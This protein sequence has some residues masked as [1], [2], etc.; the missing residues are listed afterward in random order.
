MSGATS[1]PGVTRVT[2]E[3]TTSD[4][5]AA[6]GARR[7]RASLVGL[8]LL[9][10]VLAACGGGD[11]DD[12]TD[13]DE[14]TTTTVVAAAATTTTTEAAA[15][16]AAPA[17]TPPP[18]VEYVTEGATVVVANASGINGAAGRLSER[19][20]AVDFVMAEATNSADTVGNLATSQIYY[21]PAV[22]AALAV[23]ESLKQAFGGGEIEVLEVAVPALTESGELGDANVLV[24][25]GDDIADK[26]LEE[27][28]G[29]TPPA[30]TDE[31]PDETT[32]DSTTDETT[33]DST[34]E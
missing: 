21:D 27:L 10:L 28:Q 3:P 12:T 34:D 23:A 13:D 32:D 15:T 33:D 25:M 26:S 16:T 2:T 18:A 11:D 31:T 14:T 1:V 24:L 17:T 19:L 8:A 9:S 6:A 30:E 4:F 5:P 22:E 7:L 29:L 20:A